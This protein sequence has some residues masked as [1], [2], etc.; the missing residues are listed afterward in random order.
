[1]LEED[2]AAVHPNF[3]L[4]RD[5]S[6]VYFMMAALTNPSG[7]YQVPTDGSSGRLL[8]SSLS[9]AS[10]EAEADQDIVLFRAAVGGVV[11]LMAAD[12]TG[13]GTPYSLSGSLTNH[14]VSGVLLTP[15]QQTVL[16]YASF[17]SSNGIYAVPVTGGT[18]VKLTHNLPAQ[19]E[20][21]DLH[22]FPGRFR[23]T[24]DGTRLVYRFTS[25]GSSELRVVPIDGSSPPVLLNSPGETFTHFFLDPT[26]T[27]AFFG[28]REIRRVPLDLSAPAQR[29]LSVD[30]GLVQDDAAFVPDGSAF[31]LR[32]F[33]DGL[34]RDLFVN[35]L[36]DGPVGA[37][38]GTPT[39]VVTRTH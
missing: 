29:V 21:T 4:S 17:V 32:R 7:F 35:H 11:N 31:V 33:R 20:V 15:D 14:H 34:P 24:P 6:R 2:F 16:F 25:G 22:D 5:G 19:G 1:V 38:H 27:W 26:S 10:I 8:L 36:D 28:L 13:A 12:G 37:S 39:D 18:P 23:L 9:M 3:Q 30:G